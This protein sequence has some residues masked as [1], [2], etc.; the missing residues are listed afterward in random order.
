MYTDLRF[1]GC[2]KLPGPQKGSRKR[3]AR[4]RLPLDHLKV[5]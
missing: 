1:G 2:A 4:N 3:G 5:T